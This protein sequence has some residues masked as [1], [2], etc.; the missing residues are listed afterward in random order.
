MY[1]VKPLSV[2]KTDNILFN[3]NK[4]NNQEIKFKSINNKRYSISLKENVKEIEYD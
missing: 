1:L 3:F 4:E 2:K